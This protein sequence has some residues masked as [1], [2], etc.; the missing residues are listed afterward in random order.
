VWVSA[1]VVVVSDE[2]IFCFSA[3]NG[4]EYSVNALLASFPTL[5]L[6]KKMKEIIESQQSDESGGILKF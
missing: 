3:A 4:A 5:S 1:A 2:L 6:C